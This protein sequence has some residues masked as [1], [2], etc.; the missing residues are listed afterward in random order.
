[1]IAK[2]KAGGSRPLERRLW[3]IWSEPNWCSIQVVWWAGHSFWLII[4]TVWSCAPLNLTGDMVKTLILGTTW[5]STRFCIKG[6]TRPT[7]FRHW[8]GLSVLGRMR[9]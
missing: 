6:K 4:L 5:Q 3:V 9:G 1:M 8:N 7:E 2:V